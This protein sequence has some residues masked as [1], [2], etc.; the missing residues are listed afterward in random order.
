MKT[1]FIVSRRTFIKA[2]SIQISL[3]IFKSNIKVQIIKGIR[4]IE[5]DDGTEYGQGIFGSGPYSGYKPYKSYL[6]LIQN[7]K[8][9]NE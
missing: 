7:Q 5:N 8:S 2:V 4:V 1:K 6:P 9:E 3:L